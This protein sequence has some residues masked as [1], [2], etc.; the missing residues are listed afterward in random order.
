MSKAKNRYGREA[1]NVLKESYKDGRTFANVHEVRD[2]IIDELGVKP[3]SLPVGRARNF[4]RQ[5]RLELAE[6]EKVSV[7][8][9]SLLNGFMRNPNAEA[10]ERKVT[11]KPRNKD[12]ATR[13][14]HDLIE[15]EADASQPDAT[16]LEG[17]KVTMYEAAH[18]LLEKL[19]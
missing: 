7:T 9:P 3:K 14:R 4:D 10:E 16:E 1:I 15:A 17:L 5:A 2:F 11:R 8:T 19:S 12:T 6:Q 18:K 13:V